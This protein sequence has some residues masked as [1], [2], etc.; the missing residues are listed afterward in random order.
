MIK[1]LGWLLGVSFEPRKALEVDS[2][3]AELDQAAE[4]ARARLIARGQL[5]A[6]EEAQRRVRERVRVELAA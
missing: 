2:I 1:A 4:S 6:A 5:E 3:R